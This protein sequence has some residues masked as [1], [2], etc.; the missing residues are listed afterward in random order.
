MRRCGF[1]A[2]VECSSAGQV[3][4]ED[5]LA[6]ERPEKDEQILDLGDK[7]IYNLKAPVSPSRQA[8]LNRSKAEDGDQFTVDYHYE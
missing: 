2:S 5:H 3:L 4:R 1:S 6:G 8:E 7:I